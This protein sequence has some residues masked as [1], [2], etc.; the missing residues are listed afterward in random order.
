MAE[1]DLRSIVRDPRF[2]R[3]PSLDRKVEILSRADERFRGLDPSKQ[4]EIVRRIEAGLQAEESP[5]PTPG[6]GEGGGRDPGFLPNLPGLSTET[7]GVGEVGGFALR[8]LPRVAEAFRPSES[9]LRALLVG[10]GATLGSAAGIPTGPAGVVAGGALGAAQGSLASDVAGFDRSPSVIEGV[11]RAGEEGLLD[12]AFGAGGAVVGS[13]GRGVVR[14]ATRLRDDMADLSSRFGVSLGLEDVSRNG[15][16]TRFR[17]SLGQFPLLTKP[18][19]EAT[20]RK[21]NQL[22]IAQNELLE[23][24][25][26]R[27]D[28]TLVNVEGL[29]R[30]KGLFRLFR[31]EVKKRGDALEELAK[32]TGSRIPTSFIKKRALDLLEDTGRTIPE[33]RSRAGIPDD[34]SRNP[35][36]AARQLLRLPDEIS[37]KQFKTLRRLIDDNASELNRADRA[38]DARE[39]LNFRDGSKLSLDAI[40]GPP[41]VV[42]KLQELKRFY[43]TN[44]AIFE[45]PTARK[46]GRF[47]R[48]LFSPGFEV[49]GTQESDQIIDVAFNSKSADAIR[50]L[51]RLIGPTN[52]RRQARRHVESVLDESIQINPP[53]AEKRAGEISINYK[54]LAKEF[55]L[56]RKSQDKRRSATRELLE[57]TGVTLRDLESFVKVAR[58]SATQ[59]VVEE[60]KFLRRSVQLSAAR[61]LRGGLAKG[62]SGGVLA[63]GV[64]G[65]SAAGGVF[66]GVGSMGALLATFVGLRRFGRLI[67]EPAALRSARRFMKPDASRDAR[68]QALIRLARVLPDESAEEEIAA[69]LSLGVP[70]PIRPIRGPLRAGGRLGL[71][72]LGEGIEGLMGLEQL[73]EPQR[74]GQRS[75]GGERA[76]ELDPDQLSS[77]QKSR[78]ARTGR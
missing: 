25:A 58:R 31:R 6:S 39:F 26:P 73:G 70:N 63:G 59:E 28:D 7:P 20:E 50:D 62:V 2:Q 64:A 57:G 13:A 52:F 34:L 9:D 27:V 78:E 24:I 23:E 74:R 32:R 65:G 60:A 47:D 22:A 43:A 46:L 48:N 75:G 8:N 21:A 5:Q 66:G 10:G 51:R 16:I 69:P 4:R 11:K 3:S 38:S 35:A 29:R 18:F 30:S 72:L 15:F 55:G 42:E 19:T 40:E 44:K 61:N 36:K 17:T 12:L 33:A 71:G 41:E 77:L 45:T 1:A 54:N 76:V 14:L 37:Y 53:D 68:R 56:F 67:T 49:R